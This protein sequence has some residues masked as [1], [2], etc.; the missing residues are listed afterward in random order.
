MTAE[1]GHHTSRVYVDQ[2]GDL[3]LNGA[4]VFDSNENDLSTKLDLAVETVTTTNVIAASENG[5]RYILNAAA[6]FVST[7]PAPAAGLEFWFYCGATPPSSGNH[8]IVTS[9]SA[10]IIEGSLASPEVG[11]AVA[12]VAA[13][14]T[15]TFVA[16]KAVLG[17]YAHVWS[18]GTNW[19]LDGFCFV[20]D[21][22]TTTQAS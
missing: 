4:S 19:F 11:G 18:D 5:T 20:Q 21:G 16:S 10:N 1:A 12:C 6:G 3:H 9:G 8:T 13:A 2:N 15:I 14:D 17:D 7:L 22:M